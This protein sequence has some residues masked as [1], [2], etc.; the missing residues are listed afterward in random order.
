MRPIMTNGKHNE[1]IHLK[2]QHQVQPMLLA[3]QHERNLPNP[4]I[5]DLPYVQ[6]EGKRPKTQDNNKA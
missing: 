1:S 4:S 2:H 6:L 5:I 3:T